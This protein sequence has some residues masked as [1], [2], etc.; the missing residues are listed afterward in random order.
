MR[1]G[2]LL[3]SGL[4]LMGGSL[5]A[6]ATAAGW[7]VLLHHRRPEPIAEAVARGWGEACPDLACAPR[8][9]LAVACTPV[10]H[11]AAAV[12]ALVAAGAPVVTDVGSVKGVLC[13]ALADLAGRFIGSHPMCGSHLQ[14]LAH[15]DAGLYRGAVAIVTPDPGAPPAAIAAV[16][17]LWRTLGCRLV[18]MAPADHDRAVALAS[19]LPHVLANAAA[20]RLDDAA[21]PLCAG[22]FRDVTRVAGA[23]TALWSGI[24][25]ANRREVAAA[26]RAAASDLDG[27]A[28]A[29]EADD[30]AALEAWLAGGRAG[31]AR[32]E[33]ARG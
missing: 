27:L 30:R 17:G 25:G 3:V 16:E 2:T 8:C 28:A 31:R 1:H 13:A 10:E 18:R 22:G 11:L 29:L 4:G 23:G 32:Y 20:R 7:R 15:A 9:D 24:L 33:A 21:A 6:A 14:G 12:R 19:H 26:V 5:A